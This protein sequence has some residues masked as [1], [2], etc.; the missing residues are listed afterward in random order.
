MQWVTRSFARH[1]QTPR[2]ARALR[3]AATPDN[4]LAGNVLPGR[5]R[6]GVAVGG[7]AIG[8][9]VNFSPGNWPDGFPGVLDP[10]FLWATLRTVAV[11][12]AVLR[13]GVI[14][15]RLAIHFSRLGPALRVD[16]DGQ[17]MLVPFVLKLLKKI[18]VGEQR[19]DVELPE[20]L[21]DVNRRRG[22][23]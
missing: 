22:P 9:A 3:R 5:A 16:S 8:L 23:A 13:T 12:W 20:G 1:R 11:S 21:L 6:A 7:H 19:I 15:T 17:E 10:F 2:S 18:D 4:G 14:A